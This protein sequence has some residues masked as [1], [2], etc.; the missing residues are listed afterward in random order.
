M[1]ETEYPDIIKIQQAAAILTKKA[2]RDISPDYI[3]QLR[4]DG[5]LRALNEPTTEEEKGKTKAYLF[6]RRDVEQIEIGKSRGRYAHPPKP[7]KP[8]T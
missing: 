4:R 7:D 5:R 6:L 3:R 2:G 1:S 8:T